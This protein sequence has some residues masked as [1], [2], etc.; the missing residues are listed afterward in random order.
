M[1]EGSKDSTHFLSSHERISRLVIQ[2]LKLFSSGLQEIL[3]DD[4]LNLELLVGWREG[5]VVVSGGLR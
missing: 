1:E 2:S 5:E 4:L 3:G